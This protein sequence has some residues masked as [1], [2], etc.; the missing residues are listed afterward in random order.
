M[1][2]NEGSYTTRCVPQYAPDFSRVAISI[3][4]LQRLKAFKECM[5][6]KGYRY[7]RTR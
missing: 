2:L 7:E 3:R 5:I 1:E 4:N 6:N